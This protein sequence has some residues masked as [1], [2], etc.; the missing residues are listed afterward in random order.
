MEVT[1]SPSFFSSIKRL[2]WRFY[3]FLKPYYF[4]KETLPNFLKNIWLFRKALSEHH[5][6]DHHGVLMFL[7]TGVSHM[8]ENVEKKGSE[9]PESRLKKVQAMRRLAVLIENYTEHKFVEMAE[10]EMGEIKVHKMDFIPDDDNPEYFKMLDNLT[11]EER[12][13]NNR[14]FERAGE[15]E[16][17]EWDEFCEL[18]RGQNYKNF[19]RELDFNQQLDGSGLKTWWD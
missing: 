16:K 7:Q 17:Q 4:L 12:E 13:H 11:E 5:W 18:I 3:R 10:K 19:E 2:K 1:F 9:I 15:I 8:A 6:W 14:V